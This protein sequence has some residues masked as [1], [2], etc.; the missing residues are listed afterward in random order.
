MKHR[1]PSSFPFLGCTLRLSLLLCPPPT[2]QN[3]G[4]LHPRSCSNTAVAFSSFSIPHTQ[5][6]AF[7]RL[8]ENSFE[9]LILRHKELCPLEVCNS[10]VVFV[11]SDNV[12]PPDSF[13]TLHCFRKE[14]R[15]FSHFSQPFRPSVHEQPSLC[16]RCSGVYFHFYRKP[17]LG[18]HSL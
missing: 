2:K 4:L 14:T 3:S 11:C 18:I 13:R 7:E 16:P 17:S 12:L 1:G 15:A 6:C 9:W 8:F 5:A 10:G